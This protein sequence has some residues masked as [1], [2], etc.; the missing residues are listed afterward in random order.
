MSEEIESALSND[1]HSKS[2]LALQ[3][4]TVSYPIVLHGPFVT[5]HILHNHTDTRSGQGGSPWIVSVKAGFRTDYQSEPRNYL[6]VR[7][8]CTHDGVL[9]HACIYIVIS[10]WTLEFAL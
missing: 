9:M 6:Y 10:L 4:C 7:N 1:R 2:N 5:I 3:I 8:S